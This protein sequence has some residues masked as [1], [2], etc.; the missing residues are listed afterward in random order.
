VNETRTSNSGT[1]GKATAR[2]QEKYW[3]E[4]QL[5]DE[6]DKPVTGM[7]W[8][9]ENSATRSGYESSHNGVS[10]SNGVIKVKG[11]H[12][13]DLTLSIEAQKLADEME[14]RVLRMGREI[15]KYSEVRKR[16]TKEN[17]IWQYAVIGELCR[18]YPEIEKRQDEIFPP[19]FHFPH[20]KSLK[21]L[22]LKAAQLN[23]KNIIEICPF[24][25]WELILHHQNDYS[26]ANAVNLGIA[27]S[28]SYADD[29]ALDKASISR[30]FLEQCQ[31]LSHIP[32]LYK[33]EYITHALVH[34]VP[35]SERYS[36]PVFMDSSKGPNAEG[37]TQ[38][39]YVFNTKEVIVSWRGTASGTDFLTD[40]TYEPVET[41]TDD[42]K[43]SCNG[44]VVNGKVHSGFWDGY[45]L[46]ERLFPD[47]LGELISKLG[48]LKLFICGHS[49]GGALAL[50]HSVK[51]R[52]NKPVLYTYGMPRVFTRDAVSEL[53]DIIHYRHVND[54]DPIPAVPPEANLDNWF[55]KIYGGF[56][57]TLGTIWSIPELLAYQLVEWGDCFWHH[58]NPVA[59]LT[60]TQCQQWNECKV[61]LP[62]PRGCIT[63]RKVLPHTVKLYLVP[64]LA[65]NLIKSAGEQ[66]KALVEILKPEALKEIFPEGKNF[67]RG[68]A[69]HMGMHYMTSYMPYINNNLLEL[70]DQA[71]LSTVNHFT[72]HA[73]K[74]KKFKKQMSRPDIPE[75]DLQRSKSFLAL[76]DLLKDTINPI[77]SLSDGDIALER[78][79]IYGTE[80]EEE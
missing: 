48:D 65:D 12:Y 64:A 50:I 43:L 6:E 55:F 67:D 8:R 73:E 3:I 39:F 32:R 25:S 80:Q 78:F 22:T 9:A 19:P 37:D 42:K 72:S 53:K 40:L 31:D 35:F 45:V 76:N 36:P 10:D 68:F 77:R 58:G 71:G 26:M 57:T 49:L 24:R 21:G 44:L 5:V 23:K 15:E 17:S 33:D 18:T 74:I 27:A 51:L 29:N 7:P 69:V 60:A 16:A 13:L 11:L 34:D 14:K 2:E 54:A 41:K 62:D 75:K 47:S 63:I 4:I 70:I 66:Q 30:F 38:L 52:S 28:I 56:G 1:F 46:I 61:E 59:F 20:D 79:A